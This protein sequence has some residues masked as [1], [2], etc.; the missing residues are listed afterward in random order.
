MEQQKMIFYNE[1]I[2]IDITAVGLH[3]A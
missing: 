1:I 2:S 3:T